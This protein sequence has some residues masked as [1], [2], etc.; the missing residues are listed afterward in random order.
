MISIIEDEELANQESDQI[1]QFLFYF[2][3]GKC[4]ESLNRFQRRRFKL[5]ALGYKMIDYNLYRNFFNGTLLKYVT[6]EEARRI[7]HEFYYGFSRGHYSGPTT[8][9][10][11]I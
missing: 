1:K 3:I 2:K 4:I 11:I 6:K 8:T 5:Q 9:T 7:I 10:K